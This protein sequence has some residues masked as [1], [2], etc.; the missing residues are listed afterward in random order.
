MQEPKVI[1]P[2]ATWRA[3]DR[4]VSARAGITPA[5]S[6]AACASCAGAGNSRPSPRSAATGEPQIEAIRP[7]IVVAARIEMGNLDDTVLPVDLDG[8]PIAAVLDALDAWR[9]PGPEEIQRRVPVI[10]RPVRKPEPVALRIAGDLLSRQPPELCGRP[11][12]GAAH[13]A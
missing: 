2:L 1:V 5:R 13:L 8:A 9:G 3:S 11:P 7:A 4:I 10:G 12:V 6:I